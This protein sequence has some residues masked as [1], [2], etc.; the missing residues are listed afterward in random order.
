MAK[1]LRS[2]HQPVLQVCF[3]L[4]GLSI[5]PGHLD[6]I[7]FWSVI[8][9]GTS[10]VT[11]IGWLIL[12]VFGGFIL[13][14]IAA[15]PTDTEKGPKETPERYHHRSRDASLRV[16]LLTLLLLFFQV[17]RSLGF[18]VSWRS[19]ANALRTY[20][21][22]PLKRHIGLYKIRRV[23]RGGSGSYFVTNFSGIG[24]SHA[25]HGFVHLPDETKTPFGSKNY[26]T[27]RVIGNWH[28]FK[29]TDE[30]NLDL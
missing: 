25:F 21:H 2:I 23:E 28:L 19:F 8:A 16:I 12:L 3:L 11:P 17:P 22:T 6:N 26:R 13:R 9:L 24:A 1:W 4:L 20:E 15:I 14:W 29:V 18:L 5:W 27:R 7:A 30:N 10:L